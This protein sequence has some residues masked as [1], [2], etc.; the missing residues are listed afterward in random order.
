MI[1][2]SEKSI[3]VVRCYTIIFVIFIVIINSLWFVQA[4]GDQS[5][6][7]YLISDSMSGNLTKLFIFLWSVF[8]SAIALAGLVAIQIYK[9]R[10]TK[11]TDYQRDYVLS[12]A[13]ENAH[14]ASFVDR[15]KQNRKDIYEIDYFEVRNK[16]KRIKCHTRRPKKS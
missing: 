10:F 12:L 4:L 14:V 13:K 8:S 1:V 7:E 5:F 15:I 16:L 2:H 11:A 9:D 3:K 6:I